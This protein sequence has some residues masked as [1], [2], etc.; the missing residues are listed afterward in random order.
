MP[1]I[2]NQDNFE[3]EEIAKG[4]TD[5]ISE[6][7]Q[8]RS[9]TPD[10]LTDLPGVGPSTA[11]NLRAAG[12][13]KPYELRGKS[14]QTLAAIDGIGRKTAEKI[15]TSVDY[16][17]FSGS[18]PGEG[19]AFKAR[20]DQ[21]FEE[22]TNVGRRNQYTGV[23]ELSEE[24]QEQQEGVHNRRIFM[25]Q[26]GELDPTP[27]NI[28]VQG[29][30]KEEA[31]EHMAE[32]SP[33]ERRT[34][35]SFNAQLTLDVEVWKQ[36]TDRY[37]YPGVDTIPKSRRL[38]RTQNKFAT[39]FRQ[40]E[41]SK[42]SA[43]DRDADRFGFHRPQSQTIAVDTGLATDPEATLA[44]ELGHAVDKA[45]APPDVEGYAAENQGTFEDTETREQA[46]QLA[47][48]RRARPME[49]I[50][51]SYEDKDYPFERELFAD[52][53]A[54]MLEEPRAAKREAPEA[55][56]AVQEMTAG[57]GFLPGSPL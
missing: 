39:A 28:S 22:S 24:T 53:Y 21:P 57:T 16:N 40:E 9:D 4:V 33:A 46:E 47:E 15:K 49:R 6:K 2:R 56:R 50:Q 51:Q 36:N 31:I 37:D 42:V 30:D 23:E 17:D 43:R 45:I 3:P 20:I 14:T 27:R 35:R 26:S 25:S 44:H 55:V 11:D 18:V 19:T 8:F 32:R 10:E 29:R 7:D 12:I 41:V 13:T 34:D 1:T 38:E 5:A 48:R 54:E 52:V